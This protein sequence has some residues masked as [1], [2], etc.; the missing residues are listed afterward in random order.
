MLMA[1]PRLRIRIIL[2]NGATLGPTKIALLEA[3][4]AKGSITAAARSLKISYRYAWRLVQSIN[5]IFDTPPVLT[6]VGGYNW[7]GSK[8]SLPR[9]SCCV[10]PPDQKPSRKYV[11]ATNEIV[12]ERKSSRRS[13]RR[14]SNASS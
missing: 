12:R 11:R 3:I 14:G 9:E 4:E 8:A 13:G 2:A 5:E 1:T 7:G 6:E 10:V